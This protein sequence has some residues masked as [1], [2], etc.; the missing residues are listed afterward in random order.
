MLLLILVTV[1]SYLWQQCNMNKVELEKIATG[2][3]CKTKTLQQVK[4]QHEIVQYIK[5]VQHEKKCSMKRS[6]H[7]KVQHGNVAVWKKCNIK[8]VE[9]EKS[10]TWKNINCHSEIPKKCTRMVHY[11]PWT[12]NGPSV[13]GPLYTGSETGCG[14]S[15]G[16]KKIKKQFFL[17]RNTKTYT[18]FFIRKS[19]FCLSF[20]FLN[21]LDVRVRFLNIFLNFYLFIFFNCL[22]S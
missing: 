5:R 10:A 11:S 4:M 16:E 13:D 6:Q 20:N 14:C 8:R 21:K 9:H 19:F 1:Q 17:H 15:N 2:E 18:R 7:K 12:D 22:F 3:E